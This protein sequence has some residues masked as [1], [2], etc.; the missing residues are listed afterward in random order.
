MRDSRK[1]LDRIEK[2]GCRCS[3]KGIGTSGDDLSV[4]KLDGSCGCSAFGRSFERGSDNLS[5]FGSDARLLQKEFL[6]IELRLGCITLLDRNRGC[7][8]SSQYLLA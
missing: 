3:E 6:L 4:G 1:Y 8:I 5:V 7:V 2:C